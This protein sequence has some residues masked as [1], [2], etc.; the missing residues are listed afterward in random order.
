MADNTITW[1]GLTVEVKETRDSTMD[2]WDGD[3]SLNDPKAEGYDLSVEVTVN[4]DEH[5]FKEGASVCGNWIYPD[6]EGYEYLD[7]QIKE[8]TEEALDNLGKEIARVASGEDVRKAE[9]R[10]LV[11]MVVSGLSP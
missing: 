5:E 9:T 4:V 3:E 7:S 2:P 10:K 1:R 8:L 11:A 6:R